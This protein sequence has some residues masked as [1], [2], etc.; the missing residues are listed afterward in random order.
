[1]QQIENTQTKKAPFLVI[2][3]MG[4]GIQTALQAFSEYGYTVLQNIPVTGLTHQAGSLPV[5]LTS[6]LSAIEHGVPVAFSLKLDFEMSQDV[7]NETVQ[8]LQHAYPGLKIL[9]LDAPPAVLESRFLA[10]EIKHPYESLM[11]LGLADAVATEKKQLLGLGQFKNFS[12]DT[13]TTSPKEL[14]LKIAKILGISVLPD[15]LEV[16]IKTFGFK[17]GMPTDAELVFDMR[18]MTNPFYDESLRSFTGLHA[19]VVDFLNKLPEM[20]TFFN[21]W[22]ALIETMLPLYH[23]QGKSRITIAV[24]CTGGKHRSVCMGMKL[25]DH[26]KRVFPDNPVSVYHREQTRWIPLSESEEAVLAAFNDVTEN[27]DAIQENAAQGKGDQ[28]VQ[29]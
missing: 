13:N 21:Q 23:R 27:N 2:G 10:A 14:Q 22:T 12:M 16:Y 3:P 15:P 28:P 29:C 26:L 24:G 8:T 17:Y 9:Q 18:F 5:Y 4:S 20:A 1:M 11:G 7:V 25:A 19:P 6:L